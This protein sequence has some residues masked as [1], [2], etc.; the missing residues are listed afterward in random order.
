MTYLDIPLLFHDV[1]SRDNNIFTFLSIDGVEN[2]SLLN[3]MLFARCS[4]RYVS[5]LVMYYVNDGTISE[6]SLMELA[7]IITIEYGNKWTRLYELLS[8]SYDVVD[9]TS[10][11]KTT[12][13]TNN[14]TKVYGV[15]STDGVND[16]SNTFNETTTVTKQENGKDKTQSVKNELDLR[17]SKDY[18]YISIILDD[19]KDVLTLDI[20]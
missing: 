10:T 6:N 18:D 5:T 13:D 2:A 15:D 1:F 8:T 17:R 16:S 7:N 12:H 4:N 3:S 20:Y 9:D 11:E 19:I 14:V